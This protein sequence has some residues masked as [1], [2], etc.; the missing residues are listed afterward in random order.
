MAEMEGQS[1]GVWHRYNAKSLVWYPKDDFEAAG[2]QIPET[3][4]E[5]IALMDMIVADGD[6]PWCVGIESGADQIRNQIFK[7][8]GK[9]REILKLAHQIAQY[10]VKIRYDLIID[11]PY[12]T[13]QTLKETIDLLLNLPKPLRAQS[14]GTGLK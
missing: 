13:E 1:A 14:A 5:L 10:D 4:D 2:Y 6:T 9:N 11:N 12:D 3:W 8:P 7:R